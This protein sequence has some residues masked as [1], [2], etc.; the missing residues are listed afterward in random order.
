MQAILALLAR[1]LIEA[2]VSAFGQVLLDLFQSWRDHEDAVALGRAD[3]VQAAAVA[4]QAAEQRMANVPL[5]SEEEIMK[6]L[7]EGKA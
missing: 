3:A 4:I 1:P 7:R 2:A 5:L 6:L